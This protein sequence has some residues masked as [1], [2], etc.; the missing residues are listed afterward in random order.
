MWQSLYS[1]Y[2][3]LLSFSGSFFDDFS[4]KRSVKTRGIKTFDDACA[5]D[6]SPSSARANSVAAHFEA[7]TCFL[8]FELAP[9]RTWLLPWLKQTRLPFFISHQHTLIKATPLP[10]PQFCP[11]C[12]TAF[13][14][15][16]PHTHFPTLKLLSHAQIMKV[17][18]IALSATIV[19]VAQAATLQSYLTNTPAAESDIIKSP[20]AFPDLDIKKYN[21]HVKE[22]DLAAFPSGAACDTMSA[23]K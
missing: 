20:F 13:T 16:L 4:F 21:P 10:H 8:L 2:R 23:G 17:S 5:S 12:Y 7:L 14:L 22:S 18:L 11:H 1:L 3:F 15:G 19:G 6:V 9:L